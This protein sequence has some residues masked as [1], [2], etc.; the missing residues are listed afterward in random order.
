MSNTCP[1]IAQVLGSIDS[2]TSKSVGP[3]EGIKGYHPNKG[4]ETH[5]QILG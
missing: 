2:K 1:N 4:T 5:L 3:H